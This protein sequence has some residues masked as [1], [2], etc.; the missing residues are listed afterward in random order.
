MGGCDP[1]WMLHVRTI[2]GLPGTG[3]LTIEYRPFWG[4]GD[5]G[6]DLEACWRCGERTGE[7]NDGCFAT[8]LSWMFCVSPNSGEGA[9]GRLKGGAGSLPL[10]GIFGSWPK[11]YIF[12][13]ESFGDLPGI[14]GSLPE[15]FCCNILVLC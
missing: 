11:I 3:S 10:E 14:F 9:E 6:G 4:K 2:R 5:F 7:W 15:C 12:F 13:P 1:R 8:V